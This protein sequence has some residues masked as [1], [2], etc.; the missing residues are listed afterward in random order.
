MIS[1]TSSQPQQSRID[2]AKMLRFS[3]WLFANEASREIR[4]EDHPRDS[5]PT[6]QTAA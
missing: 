1:I 6:G 5:E 2:I 4:I 3:S